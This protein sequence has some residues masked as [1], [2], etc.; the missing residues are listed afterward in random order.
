[1]NPLA[2][3]FEIEDQGTHFKFTPTESFQRLCKIVNPKATKY[4]DFLMEKENETVKLSMNVEETKPLT[5]LWK[6]KDGKW[7]IMGQSSYRGNVFEQHALVEICP[8]CGQ[9]IDCECDD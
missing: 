8:E 4:L 5:P 1:M 7:V 9:R 3:Y 6:F 2:P